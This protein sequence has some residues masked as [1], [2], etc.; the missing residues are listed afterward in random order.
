[1]E[2]AKKHYQLVFILDTVITVL[3]I[4]SMHIVFSSN[5]LFGF[6]FY[7]HD[8]NIIALIA[9][10]LSAAYSFRYLKSDRPVPQW[11]GVL[12]FA[13]AAGLT[14]TF[15]VVV[16]VLAPITG[17]GLNSYR[18]MLTTGSMLY[19]HLLC[20]IL[21]VIS[22]LIQKPQLPKRTVLWAIIPTLVY[23]AV[24]VILNL[25]HLVSG[26][27]PFLMVYDQ[28]VYMSV[29]WMIV[30]V[31]GAYLIIRLLYRLIAGRRAQKKS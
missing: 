19:Q 3:E 11:T 23:A 8:S 13:A 17:G 18:M 7:T 22:L 9:C 20:P 5:G 4:I 2:T 15:L 29:V 21:I 27:Y 26:P 28:P 31:G 30:I 25:A 14:L 16:F 10:L 6:A 12:K 24:L 1:M